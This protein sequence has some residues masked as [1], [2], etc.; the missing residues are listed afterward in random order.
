MRC[1]QKENERR[2]ARIVAAN[3]DTC[4][5]YDILLRTTSDGNGFLV[6]GIEFKG[7]L[8]HHITAT[9]GIVEDAG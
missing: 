7:R 9:I 4:N 1:E 3:A 2:V 6:L 8:V 5:T